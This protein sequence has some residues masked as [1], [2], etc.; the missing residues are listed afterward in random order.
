MSNC[1]V[2]HIHEPTP[3][4]LLLVLLWRDFLIHYYHFLI[5]Q[6]LRDLYQYLQFLSSN[7]VLLT[8]Y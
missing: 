6:G 2:D 5:L 3:S 4:N 8:D 1:Y 7:C